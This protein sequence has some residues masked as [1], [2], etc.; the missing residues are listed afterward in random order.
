MQDSML[1]A[2]FNGM[3]H[4]AEELWLFK[5]LGRNKIRYAN[6][7]WIYIVFSFLQATF[8]S[9]ILVYLVHLQLSAYPAIPSEELHQSSHRT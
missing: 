2:Q 4:S 6:V 9:N 8:T 3:R 5:E 7:L 1:A